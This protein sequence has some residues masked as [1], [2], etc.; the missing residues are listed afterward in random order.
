MAAPE[1]ETWQ[2]AITRIEPNHVRVRGYDIAELMGEVSFGA[3]VFLI[4]RGELPDERT[5]RLMDAMLVAAIDHGATPPSTLAA[6]TAASTGADLSACVA[7]GVL[8]IN[9]FHGGA[10]EEC[11][12]DLG[13]VI[14]R[15]D[16]SGRPVDQVA[17]AV[18]AEMKTEGRRFS[19]FGHRIHTDDP[20]TSRLFE[21]AE[22]AGVAGRHIEA[23]R[24][25]ERVF[26]S[27]GRAIPINV[28][29]AMAAVLADLGFE[30]RTM[31]GFFM[32]ARVPG[33]IA[34]A[35]EERERQ[36]PMRTIDPSQHAYDGPAPRALKI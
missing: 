35:V 3:A 11:A 4:L 33:L 30:P 20:R 16:E 13:Q 14:E 25:I 22:E 9:R 6:R 19:G 34:H 29:G 12:D 7:A 1:H 27:S 31:N 23:A 24:A 17:A 18:V 28:D 36:R 26:R 10:I 8:H 32:M 2:T 15:C 5:A 21:L